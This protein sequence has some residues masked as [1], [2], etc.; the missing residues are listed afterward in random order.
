VIRPAAIA[1]AVY[2]CFALGAAPRTVPPATEQA[3]LLDLKAIGG[4]DHRLRVVVPGKIGDKLATQAQREWA[5][6]VANEFTARFG[7]STCYSAIGTWANGH[8]VV[9]EPV[10]I[11]ESFATK[12]EVEAALPDIVHLCRQLGAAMRQDAVA[13]EVRGALWMIEPAGASQHAPAKGG[14]CIPAT[15]ASRG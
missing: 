8:A 10:V 6:Y 12:S 11:V 7:G 9:R 2:L 13:L 4:R 15:V 3:V 14:H 1:A 5:D